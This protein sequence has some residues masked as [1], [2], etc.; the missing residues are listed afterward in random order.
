MV[1]VVVERGGGEAEGARGVSIWGWG[2][3]GGG[4]HLVGA[5]GGLS[6]VFELPATE[7]CQFSQLEVGGGDQ[8]RRDTVVTDEVRTG[9]TT[10]IDEVQHL[11]ERGGRE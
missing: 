11:D 3:G 5:G 7:S 2:G 10:C 4:G 1:L 6:V 9:Q 8:Q